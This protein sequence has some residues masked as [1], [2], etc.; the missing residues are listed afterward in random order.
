M[1]Y[2]SCYT[3]PKF[4]YICKMKIR[5]F[6]KKAWSGFVI[7]SFAFFIASASL[8][9]HTHVIGDTI[10]THSHPY[11]KTSGADSHNHTT[12][13]LQAIAQLTLLHI[14]I[15]ALMLISSVL[16]VS[17]ITRESENTL[18]YVLQRKNGT[19]QRGPP[20]FST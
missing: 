10:I 15:S 11:N 3:I 4:Y 18:F 19:S 9:T 8:F 5:R 7:L 13:Q 17:E 12:A 1:I 6:L 20:L 2:E 14:V 16:T